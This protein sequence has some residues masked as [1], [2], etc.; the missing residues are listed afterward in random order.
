VVFEVDEP[1]F[2]FGSGEQLMMSI[3]T[4][5]V[6]YSAGCEDLTSEVVAGLDKNDT[7]KK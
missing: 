1:E 7:T 6:L 4:H 3:Q 5:K 2:P